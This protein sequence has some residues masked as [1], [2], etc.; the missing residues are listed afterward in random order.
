MLWNATSAA[1]VRSPMLRKLSIALVCISAITSALAQ[2]PA[3]DPTARMQQIIQSYVDNKQFMGTVPGL[4][5]GK[6]P[7]NQGYGSADLEWNIP[8]TPSVKF[9]LG[10]L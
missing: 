7:N 4:K 9:R 5:D 10:S 3:P 8:N 2:A 6:P 1:C